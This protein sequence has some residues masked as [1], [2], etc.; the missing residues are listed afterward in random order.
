MWFLRDATTLEGGGRSL[1]SLIR[2]SYVL[3]WQ[4]LRLLQQLVQRPEGSQRRSSVHRFEPKVLRS[5]Q[6]KTI[7]TYQRQINLFV[8]WLQTQR[9]EPEEAHEWDDAICA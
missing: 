6:P 9:L 5:L 4:I 1:L 8:A 2:S 7:Q 3:L